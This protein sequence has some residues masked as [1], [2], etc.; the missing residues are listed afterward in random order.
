ML[1]EFGLI[2]QFFQQPSKKR[3]DV[4]LGIGDDCALLKVPAGYQLAVSMDTLVADVHFAADT[5]PFDIGYKA[6]AVNLSDLAAMA[7]E[8]AWVTLALT[9]PAYHVDWLSHFSQGF[10]AAAETFDLQLIGGDTTRGPLS[11][12]LQVHGF[13]PDG[14]ALTRSGARPGDLI[15][16]TGC[17]GDAGLALQLGEAAPLALMQRLLRPSPRVHEGLLLRDMA[18]SA[19]D[20]SDGLAADLSHIL[21]CSQVGATLEVER[22]P[23]SNELLAATHRLHAQTLALTAGDDYELCFTIAPQHAAYLA[24][25]PINCTCI[26]TI[27]SSLGLRVQSVDGSPLPLTKLGY[28]HF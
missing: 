27:E 20:I 13:I 1:N 3:T 6:L 19:I 22:L 16:V 5:A 4:V 21:A 2:Q 9:L 15:Y 14:K 11:M 25:L 18:T 23:L 8:P 17:L 12:T 26:G 28:S 10:F 24:Q 7:A